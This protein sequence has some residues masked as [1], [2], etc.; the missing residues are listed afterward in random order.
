[1]ASVYHRADHGILQKI[2]TQL[3]DNVL[4][5]RAICRHLASSV[6]V[7]VGLPVSAHQKDRP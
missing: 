7:I 6:I 1:M 5:I 4:I 2:A 3:S